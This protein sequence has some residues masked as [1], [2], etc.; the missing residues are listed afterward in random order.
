MRVFPAIDDQ[1][2]ITATDINGNAATSFTFQ[3]NGLGTGA[4]GEIAAAVICDDRGNQVAAGGR[5]SARLIIVTPLGRSTVLTDPVQIQNR[6][7]C[8]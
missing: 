4:A 6:G 2:D 7:G 1:I 8:P 5:S 3:P